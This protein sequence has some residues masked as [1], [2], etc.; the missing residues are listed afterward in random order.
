[1]PALPDGYSLHPCDEEEI[2]SL[3]ALLR[4]AFEDENWTVDK[5]REALIDAPDVKTTHVITHQGQVIATASSRLLPEYYPGSGYLHWV[6]SHPDFRGQRLGYIISLAV[7]Y[8]FVEIGCWDAVLET[9]DPRIPAIKTYF[10]LDFEPVFRDDAERWE[11]I[12]AQIGKT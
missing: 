8:E 9:Q 4:A 6:A 2:D 1:M 12:R 11:A 5:A 7:L 10:H 3:V